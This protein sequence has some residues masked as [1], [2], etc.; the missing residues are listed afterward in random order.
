MET[1]LSHVEKMK[2][3]GVRLSGMGF[4][5]YKGLYC[6]IYGCVCRG[7]AAPL[8]SMHPFPSPFIA[9]NYLKCFQVEAKVGLLPKHEKHCPP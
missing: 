9:I 6:L 7:C 3:M 4:M 5:T 2:W 8:F 1:S